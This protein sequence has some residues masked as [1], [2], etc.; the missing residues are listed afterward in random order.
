M[1]TADEIP[2]GRIYMQARPETVELGWTTSPSGSAGC[3]GHVRAVGLIHIPHH[4]YV[5]EHKVLGLTRGERK[6]REVLC[7]VIV[8]GA[9]SLFVKPCTREMLSRVLLCA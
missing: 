8:I 7:N 1:S 9:S 3:S 2:H 6:V 4:Y 5:L